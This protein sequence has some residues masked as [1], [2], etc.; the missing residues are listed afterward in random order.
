MWF[1]DKKIHG[2]IELREAARCHFFNL[3]KKDNVVCPELDDLQFNR[4]FEESGQMLEM[5]FSEEKV[6]DGLKLCNGNKTLRLYR[7]NMKFLQSF[8][9]L[10]KDDIMCIFNEL[11]S[12]GQFFKSL[13]TTFITLIPKRNETN[14]FKDFRLVSLVRYVYKLIVK[15]LAKRL[16]KVL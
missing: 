11:Y 15:V 16:S 9:Y 4:I 10:S 5:E 13:N 8:W 3:Y 12:S 6:F 2:N 1:D 14:E 7:F